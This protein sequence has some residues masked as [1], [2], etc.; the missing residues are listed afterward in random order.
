VIVLELSA[1]GITAELP[2]GWEGRIE[3]RA[4]PA[5]EARSLDGVAL[6]GERTYP[7]AHLANFPLPP[8]RGDFGSGAVELMGD[9][10]VF[11]CLFEY[12]PESVGTALFARQGMPRTLSPSLFTADQLQRTIRGQAG[13]QTFFTEG[14]RAFTLF[15]VLGNRGRSADLVPLVDEMLAGLTIEPR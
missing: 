8:D 15:V 12:G 14:G 7:I 6:T 10:N 9:G 11:V 13:H 1:Y 5:P 4:E 3:R 2:P